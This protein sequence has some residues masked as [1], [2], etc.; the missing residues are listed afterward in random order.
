MHWS[1]NTAAN[2]N[3]RRQELR[4][5]QHARLRCVHGTMRT[6]ATRN[7][8]ADASEEDVSVDYSELGEASAV[9]SLLLL[10]QLGQLKLSM[11]AHDWCCSKHRCCNLLSV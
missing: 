9:L 7:M 11:H 8:P 6:A 10:S 5:P 2:S 1:G 3:G 4:A